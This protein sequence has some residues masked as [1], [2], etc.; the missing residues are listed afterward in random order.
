MTASAAIALALISCTKETG[1]P[2][3]IASTPEPI[4]SGVT[5]YP[6]KIGAPYKIGSVSYVPED[7]AMYDDV[8][9]ASWYGTEM[10][11]RPTAN[12]EIFVPAGV[13]AAHKTLPMPSYAEVTSL[14]TGRTI[15]VRINDRGPFANDR[16]IDLSEGAARQLG[17]V[18]QGVAGVRVRRVNPPEQERSALRSG[19]A[20]STRMD[21]PESLLKVLREKL[22]KLPKPSVR[23][24]TPPIAAEVLRAANEQKAAVAT[25]GSGR[26]VKERRGQASSTA[27]PLPAP[28]AATSPPSGGGYVVQLGAFSTRA[29]ADTVAGKIGANVAKSSDGRIYRVRFGPFASEAEAQA[30]LT[31]ARQKGYPQARLFRE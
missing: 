14:D 7:V 25:T 16:L 21:T 23:A 6:V 31:K 29:R 10:E 11:G 13:S 3:R 24:A 20:A 12:G 4:A 9:Y 5:D 27:E 1:K 2:G 30:A 19:V 18:G 26:F 28:V 8:G 17:I 22:A 15:L